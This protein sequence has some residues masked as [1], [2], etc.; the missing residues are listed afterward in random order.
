LKIAASL[1]GKIAAR[2]GTSRWITGEEQVHA[3]ERSQPSCGNR[4]GSCR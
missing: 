2:D 1:D 4:H 3:C